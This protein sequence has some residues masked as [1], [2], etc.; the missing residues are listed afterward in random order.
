VAR[1]LSNKEIGRTLFI[2][3]KTVQRHMEGIFEKTKVRTRAAAA[4]FAVE[5]DLV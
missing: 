4:V 1:G 3:P 2:S 5:H